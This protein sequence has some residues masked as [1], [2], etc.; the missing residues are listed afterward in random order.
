MGSEA[1]YRTR[2]ERWR[3]EAVVLPA[4]RHHGW[5]LLHNAVSHPLLGVAPLQFAIDFHDWTSMRLNRRR[6]IKA[7]PAPEISHP[8][9]WAVHNIIG[10]LAIGLLPCTAT[11]AYHDQSAEA[12][13]EPDWL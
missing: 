6:Q 10:H 7:S 5:W 4:L 11:F 2:Q 1:R 3:R 9:R 12:M 8:L 13:A